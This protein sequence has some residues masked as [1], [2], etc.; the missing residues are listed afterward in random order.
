MVMV[1]KQRRLALR[2][3]SEI[4]PN[5]VRI[6]E[7]DVFNEYE[8]VV[9]FEHISNQIITT[10]N[11]SKLYLVICVVFLT[12][13]LFN[14]YDFYFQTNSSARGPATGRDV[15]ASLVW[16]S[17]ATLGTWMR[18]VKYIGIAC[19]GSNIFFLDKKGKQNPS[20]YLQNILNTRNNYL[21]Q[22]SGQSADVPHKMEN[23]LP[24][25]RH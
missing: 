19:A 9:P 14:V 11:I 5:G 1:F 15:I 13:F 17:V 16:L 21:Q 24:E 12:L 18:S 6:K 8:T 4:L 2:I 22:I 25:I 10:F 23:E 7:K 20:E 3:E